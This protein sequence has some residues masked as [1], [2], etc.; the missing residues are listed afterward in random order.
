MEMYRIVR[1]SEK[2][3]DEI[4]MKR[5]MSL[6]LAL[7]MLFFVMA[8]CSAKEE[9]QIPE[10]TQRVVYDSFYYFFDYGTQEYHQSDVA[11]Y[12]AVTGA[13][14][15][16]SSLDW[17]FLEGDYSYVVEGYDESYGVYLYAYDEG[18]L[19]AY[20][21]YLNSIGFLFTGKEQFTEGESYFFVNQANGF[22]M[23]LFVAEDQSYV[24]VEPYVEA[25]ETDATEAPATEATENT[26]PTESVQVPA[27]TY[28]EFFY[29]YDYAT[30]EYLAS[31]VATYHAVTGAVCEFSVADWE[32]L[33]N[34]DYQYVTEGYDPE[35]G[36]FLYPYN[37]AQMEDYARYLVLNGFL[38]VKTEDYEEGTS[39]FY[40]NKITG[41]L[42]DIFVMEGDSYVVVEPYTNAEMT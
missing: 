22:M 28:N 41:M 12:H 3:K 9:E 11:T 7:L 14:C 21:H 23:D 26:Q 29:F 32:F 17:T 25:D 18:Q 39:Y 5:F 33:T 42:M 2:R 30:G 24:A 37:K 19:E 36:L 34:E 16:L 31:E 13:E 8:G 4:T 27:D 10:T 20:R 6:M 35:Y 15:E 40:E 38:C 1:T